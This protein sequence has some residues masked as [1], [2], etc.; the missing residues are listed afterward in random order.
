MSES[1]NK[2]CNIDQKIGSLA[3]ILINVFQSINNFALGVK[4]KTIEATEEDG[5]LRQILLF[6]LGVFVFI[7]FVPAIPFI[8]MM[9][10]FVAIIK[11]AFLKFLKI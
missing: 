5:I 3:N 10:I 2:N 7:T 4:E 6:F 8:L 11:W 1:N 9:A